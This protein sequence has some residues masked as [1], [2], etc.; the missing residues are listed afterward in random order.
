MTNINNIKILHYLD[1]ITDSHL[2][3]TADIFLTNIC[4]N[5]CKY[6]TYKRHLGDIKEQDYMSF[7]NFTKYV[8][9]LVN[10]GIKGIILTGGGEPTLNPDFDKITTWLEENNIS[11]G[12]NTNLNILKYCSPKYLKISLDGYD[13]KSY[14]EIRGTHS[15]NKVIKNIK[16][17]IEYKNKKAK[18]TKVGIQILV[19]NASEILNFYE[20]HKHLDVNYF[21][22]RPNEDKNFH[23]PKDELELILQNLNYLKQNDP[24]VIINYKWDYLDDNCSQC[25]AHWSQIALDTA[26]NVLFCCHKPEEIVGHIEDTDIFYKHYNATLNKNTCDIPCRLTGPNNVLLN[27]QQL[28]SDVEFI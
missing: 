5:N 14:Y 21:N 3:I 25:L 8:T 20:A 18:D 11:Y 27:I 26:G 24:R 16:D 28:K 6:C 12:I 4:N 22:F 15:Y 13:E 19:K 10:N 7:E 1:R 2:P 9:I 17:F 23:Y